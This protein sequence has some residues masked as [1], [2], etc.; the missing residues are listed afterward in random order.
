MCTEGTF[1]TK[2]VIIPSN[3][4]HLWS[5]LRFLAEGSIL[6]ILYIPLCAVL[7]GEILVSSR[8]AP[9]MKSVWNMD[10]LAHDNM[11]APPR[12]NDDD[13]GC[14]KCTATPPILLL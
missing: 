14:S 4:C 3:L 6:Q 9:R 5:A 10:G 8:L 12:Q 1:I 7:G 2:S 13:D 11:S